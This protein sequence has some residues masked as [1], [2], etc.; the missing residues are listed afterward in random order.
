M[1]AIN[2]TMP[3]GINDGLIAIEID[4]NSINNTAIIANRKASQFGIIYKSPSIIDVFIIL[5]KPSF[6]KDEVEIC[7]RLFRVV[8]III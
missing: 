1:V 2:P 8:F 7:M 6:V 3:I 4:M 5:C